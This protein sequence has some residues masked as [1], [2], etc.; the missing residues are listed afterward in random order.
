MPDA[1]AFF[2]RLQRLAELL[3]VGAEGLTDLGVLQG[4]LHLRLHDLELVAH[5]VVLAG[6]LHRRH[7]A[8]AAGILGHGVGQ[9]DLAAC[10]GLGL[11]EDV[12]DLGRQQ[13]AAK[14]GVVAEL[15]PL[16]GLLDHVVHEEVVVVDGGWS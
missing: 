1:F 6:E 16:L 12:V 14:D 10:A 2:G 11:G 15:L 13:D 9:L 3:Q 8:V 7:A 5:V 4:Q